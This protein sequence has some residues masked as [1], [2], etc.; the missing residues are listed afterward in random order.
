MTDMPALDSFYGRVQELSMVQHWI[1]DD[2]SCTTAIL[3]GGGAGKT[4][5]AVQAVAQVKD[6]FEYIFW[7]S[8][9][10]ASS[11]T[12]PQR[13]CP[14]SFRSTALKHAR[15][16]RRSNSSPLTLPA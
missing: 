9:Q 2:F 4:A 12:R 13:V 6:S 5:L 14:L 15:R 10:N 7:R 1:Q 3:G 16:D 8:L 11:G